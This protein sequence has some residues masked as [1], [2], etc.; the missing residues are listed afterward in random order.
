[1][2]RKSQGADVSVAFERIHRRVTGDRAR[3]LLKDLRVLEI[4]PS[5]EITFGITE[6]GAVCGVNDDPAVL[7]MD[8]GHNMFGGSFWSEE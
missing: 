5:Q 7:K 1:M 6:H 3:G 2:K 4:A 8:L